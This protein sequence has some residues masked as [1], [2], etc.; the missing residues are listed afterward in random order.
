MWRAAWR[1]VLDDEAASSRAPF[2]SRIQTCFAGGFVGGEGRVMVQAHSSNLRIQPVSCKRMA[3]GIVQ[4]ALHAGRS[5]GTH[6]I[7]PHS[8]HAVCTDSVLG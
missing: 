6:C 1:Q 8:L 3:P 5:S 7:P 2:I 4:R